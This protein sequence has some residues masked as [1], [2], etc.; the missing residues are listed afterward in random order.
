LHVGG[1]STPALARF[2]W[3]AGALVG[4]ERLGDGSCRI[5]RLPVSAASDR[6]GPVQVLASHVDL[7]DPAAT[8]VTDRAVYY[9]SRE[10]G[11]SGA[12]ETVVKRLSISP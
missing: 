12:S 7:P 6:A 10:K 8:T 9:V 2:R 1:E 5:L 11:E 4:I 3:E